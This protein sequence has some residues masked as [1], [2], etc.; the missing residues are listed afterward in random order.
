M[1]LRYKRAYRRCPH[2]DHLAEVYLES[3]EQPHD[4]ALTP[5]ED[6]SVLFS[7]PHQRIKLIF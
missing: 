3:G 1:D 6:P 4:L 5:S 2:N 7:P